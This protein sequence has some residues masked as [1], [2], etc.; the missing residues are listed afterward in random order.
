MIGSYTLLSFFSLIEEMLIHSSMLQGHGIAFFIVFQSM[1][2]G[3]KLDPG[4]MLNLNLCKHRPMDE[5]VLA[6]GEI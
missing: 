1:E 2:A 3:L 6:Q 4:R 5:S